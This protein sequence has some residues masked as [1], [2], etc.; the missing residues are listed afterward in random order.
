MCEV[1]SIY[2]FF[3]WGTFRRSRDSYDGLVAQIHG[4]VIRMKRRLQS[5]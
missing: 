1:I 3:A 2:G 5:R 4:V